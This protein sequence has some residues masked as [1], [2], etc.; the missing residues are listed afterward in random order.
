L[1][2]RLNAAAA[3]RIELWRAGRFLTAL[4]N[5]AFAPGPEQLMWN[6]KIGTSVARDGSY[7]VVV[8][9]TDTLTT[10]SQRLRITVDTTPP[11]LRLVSRRRLLFWTSEA[12]AVTAS[13]GT[14]RVTRQVQGGYFGF[15]ALRGARHFS[16]TAIDAAGNVSRPL[17]G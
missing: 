16:L 2:F 8:K 14:R 12:A 1:S 10:V 7:D 15:P 4:A 3:V 9:A 13:F 11:R 6:G 5:Q 17:S